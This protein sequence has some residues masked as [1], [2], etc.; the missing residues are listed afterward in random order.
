MTLYKRLK[1]FLRKT[2]QFF[3]PSLLVIGFIVDVVTFRT[4]SP[5][6]TFM[7]T[8]VYAGL[9]AFA[10]MYSNVYDKR[11]DLGL[12]QHGFFGYLRLF[13]GF[14]EQ[15][16]FG[17][18]LSSSLLF[19]WFSGSF[20]A[21]WPIMALLVAIMASNEVMRTYYLRPSVQIGVFSFV[22][23]SYFSV[24]FPFVFRSLSPWIFLAGAGVG[25]VIVLIMTA[26]MVRWKS[27]VDHLWG[28]VVVVSLSVFGVMTGLYFL[29]VIPPIPLFI[30]DAGMYHN[31]SVTG[32]EYVLTHQ[33]ES[34]VES[35]WPGQ[36][37]R[38]DED[39]RV[40]AYT[41]IFAPEGLS[42]TIVHEWQ[43]FDE[44]QKKWITSSR[45][46]FTITGGRDAGFRG[47]SFHTNLEP[48][49]WRVSVET[50]RG[51]VLGRIGFTFEE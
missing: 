25:T 50:E 37:I 46:S 38:E 23:M 6:T 48:G 41:A 31:I 39:G 36:T 32:G 8:G 33:K 19:Y 42:T 27:V 4:L 2:E 18:L 12:M 22:L 34:L 28:R 11:K 30:R 16:T 14:V 40:Y 29:N 10:I 13:T 9:A 24:L 15:F 45:P 1:E 17:A 3:V 26:F 49:R 51:Q 20:A 21:S 5:M 7:I 44:T 47:Y 43:H 35:L